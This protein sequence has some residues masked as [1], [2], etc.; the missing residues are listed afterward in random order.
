MV[1]EYFH[2]VDFF[3]DEAFYHVRGKFTRMDDKMDLKTTLKTS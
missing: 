3:S 1:F 2:Y